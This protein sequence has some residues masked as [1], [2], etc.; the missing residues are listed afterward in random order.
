MKPEVK[1]NTLIGD[2]SMSE[3]GFMIFTDRVYRVK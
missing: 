3:T 2:V 1:T